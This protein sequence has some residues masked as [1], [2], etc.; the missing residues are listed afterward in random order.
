MQVGRK[1]VGQVAKRVLPGRR[2]KRRRRAKPGSIQEGRNSMPIMAENVLE[3]CRSAYIFERNL[4][5]SVVCKTT[6]TLL[7]R[8][9]L[10]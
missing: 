1:S 5:L 7:S 4:L 10:S 2:Q 9:T 8:L 6:V 3:V